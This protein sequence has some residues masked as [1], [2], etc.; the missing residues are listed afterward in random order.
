MW[1]N[2]GW[3][4]CH[5]FSVHYFLSWLQCGLEADDDLRDMERVLVKKFFFHVIAT[6]DKLVSGERTKEAHCARGCFVKTISCKSLFP[7]L[8]FARW[9]GR[10]SPLNLL[11]WHAKLICGKFHFFHTDNVPSVAFHHVWSCETAMFCF[12]SGIRHCLRRGPDFLPKCQTVSETKRSYW[13]WWSSRTTVGALT[14]ARPVSY[15]SH[16]GPCG[17]CG[18]QWCIIGNLMVYKSLYFPS[19]SVNDKIDIFK[20]KTCQTG[21]YWELMN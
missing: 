7:E 6:A 1:P 20:C 12:D 11:L 19:Q 14:A 18:R 4:N 8:Q 2:K 13:S 9:R 16:L 10:R 15:T 17:W 3:T 21:N 5:T